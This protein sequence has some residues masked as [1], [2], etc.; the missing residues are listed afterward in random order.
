MPTKT[1]RPR[2]D[3]SLFDK[4]GKLIGV[5]MEVERGKVYTV[6]VQKPGHRFP[7]RINKFEFWA[8]RHGWRFY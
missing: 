5:I 6:H 2:K 1:G 4:D 3:E 7:T 8:N